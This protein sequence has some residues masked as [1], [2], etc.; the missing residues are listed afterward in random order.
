MMSNTG[1]AIEI[2]DGDY[3]DVYSVLFTGVNPAECY[4]K[5]Y[6]WD[7]GEVARTKRKT[8]VIDKFLLYNPAASLGVLYRLEVIYFYQE[9]RH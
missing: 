1:E 4:R 7:A 2:E 8:K 5:Y 3:D 6:K 9:G